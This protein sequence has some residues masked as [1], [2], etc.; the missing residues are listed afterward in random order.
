M[1]S[2][3]LLLNLYVCEHGWADLVFARL[4]IKEE[5]GLVIEELKKEYN[6]VRANL[7]HV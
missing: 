5:L 3:I 2:V 7:K 4:S 1:L 6:I